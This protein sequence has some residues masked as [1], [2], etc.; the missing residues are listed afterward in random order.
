MPDNKNENTTSSSYAKYL[1]SSQNVWWKRFLNVQAPYRYNLRKINSGFTLDIG[2]GIGRNLHHIN[3]NGVGVDHNKESVE[4][5]KRNG[6]CVFT[7]EEFEK[8]EF[9]LP[10]RFDSILLCHV[11][12]HMHINE[13]IELLAKYMQLLKRG[14]KVILITPQEVG[15]RSDKTHVEFMDFEKLKSIVNKNNCMLIKHYSFPFIRFVGKLFKYNE[16]VVIAKKG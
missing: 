10:E 14:G 8:S 5:A 6:L 9:N 4:I 2:C 12:E 7:P 15:F 16:F 3:G 13:V 1:S 11:A